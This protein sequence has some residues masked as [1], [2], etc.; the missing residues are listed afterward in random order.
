MRAWYI[1]TVVELALASAVPSPFHPL[2][3]YPVSGVAEMDGLVPWENEPLPVTEPPDPAS[4]VR[5]YEFREKEAERVRAWDIS[6]VVELALESAVP[7]PFHPSKE[8]PVSGVAEM[9]GLDPWEKDPLPVTEPP[10]PA[11]TVRS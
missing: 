9:D 10:D 11:S 1:S 3:E 8:Y 5:S 4:T 6:T 2:K 7:S